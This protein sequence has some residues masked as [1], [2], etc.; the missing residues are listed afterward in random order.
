M[1]T[2]NGNFKQYFSVPKSTSSH[3]QSG[4]VSISK[5]FE[6]WDKAGMKM[7]N[8]PLYEV[9]MKVES[10]T[11]SA[12]GKGS[13]KV[14]KNLLTLGGSS[15]IETRGTTSFASVNGKT[16]NVTPVDG[17]RLQVRIVDVHGKIKAEFHTTSSTT[18]SL[19]NIPAGLYFLDVKGAAAKQ[20]TPIVLE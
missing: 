6:G 10:Y 1:L 18:F 13:A 2:G 15:V 4:T 14:T 5:H 7:L 11:G 17:S 8:N 16:L 3:R 19:S 20:S 12:T 9:A